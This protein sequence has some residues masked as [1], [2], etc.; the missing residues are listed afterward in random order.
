MNRWRRI[1]WVENKVRAEKAENLIGGTH[2]E[3]MLNKHK[4]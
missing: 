1:G 3:R 2:K 4:L